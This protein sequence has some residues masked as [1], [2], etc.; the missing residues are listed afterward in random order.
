MLAKYAEG[1]ADQSSDWKDDGGV[2][3]QHRL[4]GE[5]PSAVSV[6]ERGHLI[7]AAAKY[8]VV[9]S[10][11]GS[12]IGHMRKAR[13]VLT[14]EE[15]VVSAEFF[16]VKKDRRALLGLKTCEEFGLVNRVHEIAT[17]MDIRSQTHRG[18]QSLF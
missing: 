17:T 18:V 13:P 9:R 15:R 14:L 1:L 5:S 12:P 8:G 7:T 4:P 16:V 3:G 11:N 10:Y 6:A 2:Q